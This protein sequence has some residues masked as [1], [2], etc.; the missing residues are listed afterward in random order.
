MN[1]LYDAIMPIAKRP[2][3]IFV[4]GK[5]SYLSD[6][7]GKVFLDFIQGWAVNTLGHSHPA[8]VYAIQQQAKSLINPSPGFYNAQM[9]QLANTLVQNSVFEHVFFANSG[10]EANEGAIKLAR[11]WGSLQKNKAYKIICFDNGFHGRTLATMSASGKAGWDSLFQPEVA[12]FSKVPFN[13]LAAVENAIDEQTVA[14]MLEPIQGEAGVIPAD[15]GFI[16]ALRQ[17][18]QEQKLLL[19]FDEIQT[20]IGRTGKLFC[21]QH[22]DIEPDI[23]TLGKGLGGG[24]PLS[25]LLAK[26]QFS[27]FEAG[28]QGGTFNGN[29]LVTA[30]GNAVL[31]EILRPKFL[32]DVLQKSQY[33][34]QCLTEL[35]SKYQ[36][37]MV[38]GRG[39]LLALDTKNIDAIK[40][41][42]HCYKQNLLINA[43]RKNCLRFMPA[44]TV[45]KSEIEQMSKL[46]DK[47][48][49][50]I[51]KT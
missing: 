2:E 17:L 40:I 44:L 51:T 4:S 25:A 36:L 46:L 49:A 11:K 41:V 26:K 24:V 50:D 30:A 20:G 39:L 8:L 34:Q 43:P 12:G 22:F 48:L 16:K 5:G 6:D 23:M 13:N 28:D 27:C 33:L 38:R 21:Y 31:N 18:T 47:V 10:A 42:Q 37:G 35:S 29:P 14:V 7:Q 1:N 15:T 32:A 3:T 19:I 9:I 45:S